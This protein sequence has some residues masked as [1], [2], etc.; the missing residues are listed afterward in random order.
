[1]ARNVRSS[2]T[3]VLTMITLRRAGERSYGRHRM[4]EVWRTFDPENGEDALANGFGTLET[5]DEERF[6]PGAG[7]PRRPHRDTEIVT[8]V[9]EG[10]LSHEDSTGRSGVIQAGEFQRMS[11]GRGIRHSETNASQTDSAHAFQIG[12]RPSEAGLES[13]P[14]QRRF[15]TAERRDGLCV[16]ASQDGRRGSLHIHQDALIFSALMD[17]GHHVVHELAPGRRAWLHLVKGGL[18]LGDVV[19]NTGD[20]AGVTAER[21]ISFTALEDT[22]VLL[23]ELS[24][25]SN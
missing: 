2:E 4:R 12:L 18:T 6:A 9:C 21:A 16:V 22:S 7:G 11:S 5:L 1:M 23:L 3:G 24:E 20:G 25:R 8:Y 15:S 14:E 19:L 13:G 10:T 17:I